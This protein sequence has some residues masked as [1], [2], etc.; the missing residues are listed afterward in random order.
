MPCLYFLF[1]NFIFLIFWFLF[2]LILNSILFVFGF[3][4]CFPG[5]PFLPSSSFLL[6]CLTLDFLFFLFFLQ[7]EME[8]LEIVHAGNIETIQHRHSAELERLRTPTPQISNSPAPSVD[9][10][11]DGRSDASTLFSPSKSFVRSC[12]ESCSWSLH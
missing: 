7:A 4:S 3:A 2:S 6:A 1:W 12:C 11:V 8:R 10:S 5:F 9:Y